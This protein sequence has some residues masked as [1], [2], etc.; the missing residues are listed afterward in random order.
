MAWVKHLSLVEFVY[1]N[2][3]QAS[4]GMAP[5]EALYGRNH[6]TPI[7]W[8]EVG[9]RKVND[10]ELVEVTSKKIQI[11]QERLKTAQDQQKSYADIR[12]RELEFE[13]GD[14]VF[15]KVVPWKGVIHF[16]KEAN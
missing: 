1:N 11:I 12:M 16:R 8:D 15:L 13:D 5:Y 6:R 3:Y 14:M 10:V 4:I 2:S 9:E 7:C